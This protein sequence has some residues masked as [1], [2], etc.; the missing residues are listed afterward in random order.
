MSQKKLIKGEYISVTIQYRII[1]VSQLGQALSPAQFDIFMAVIHQK[2]IATE[3][4]IYT[5]CHTITAA[6]MFPPSAC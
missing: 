4:L 3:S 2:A 6:P 1:I 5:H